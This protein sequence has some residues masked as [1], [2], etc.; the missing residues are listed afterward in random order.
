[1]IIFLTCLNK[2]VVEMKVL[3]KRAN[4]RISSQSRKNYMACLGNIAFRLAPVHKNT[5]MYKVDEKLIDEKVA[6]SK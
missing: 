3:V 6:C 1:M 2:G 5:Q 4:K